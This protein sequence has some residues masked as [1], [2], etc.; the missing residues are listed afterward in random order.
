ME[1]VR[2][3]FNPN[4]GY[5]KVRNHPK[6]GFYVEKLS[7]NAVATFEQVEKVR[8]RWLMWRVCSCEREMRTEYVGRLSEAALTIQP[9]AHSSWKRAARRERLRPPT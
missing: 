4:A 5:L 3:L 9:A 6:V 2:D 1:K 8:C 7:K